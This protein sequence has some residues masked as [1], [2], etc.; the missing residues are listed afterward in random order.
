MTPCCRTLIG[1]KRSFSLLTSFNAILIFRWV[2]CF[3]WL[4]IDMLRLMLYLV[5]YRNSSV[6][7]ETAQMFCIKR[8]SPMN[9][10][11]KK[12]SCV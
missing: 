2:L 4:C 5:L 9:V 7:G 8:H 10:L 6:K 1:K 12:N 3:S 11:G